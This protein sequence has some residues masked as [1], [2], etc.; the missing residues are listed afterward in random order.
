MREGPIGDMHRA[1]ERT[2]VRPKAQALTVQ[3]KRLVGSGRG[4]ES[5]CARQDQDVVNPSPPT[6]RLVVGHHDPELVRSWL[7]P[8]TNDLVSFLELPLTLLALGGLPDSASLAGN[9]QL[10]TSLV[11]TIALPLDGPVSALNVAARALRAKTDHPRAVVVPVPTDGSPPPLEA[12]VAVSGAGLVPGADLTR[13]EWVEADAIWWTDDIQSRRLPLTIS[14]TADA[15]RC[16]HL[17]S[18]TRGFDAD[19]PVGQWIVDAAQGLHPSSVEDW[20]VVLVVQYLEMVAN[21]LACVG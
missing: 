19:A 9:C 21:R 20:S 14:S 1:C 6:P 17:L 12:L 4:N 3:A 18:A 2:S 10:A 15:R 13:V 7:L 5:G 11:P 16:A 8:I